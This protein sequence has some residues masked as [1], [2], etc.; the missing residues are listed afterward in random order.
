MKRSSHDRH[1]DREWLIPLALGLLALG[2]RLPGLDTGLWNDEIA[3]IIQ[4]FR[5]SFPANLSEFRGDNKHPL[6]ALLAHASL[7]MFGETAW[8]IRL[9]SLL[10]GVASVPMLYWLAR[11]LVGRREAISAALLLAV[12]YHHVWFSQSARGYSALLFFALLTTHQLLGMLRRS[13]RRAAIAFAICIALGTYAHL[14]FVFFVFTQFVVALVALAWP[15]RGTVRPDWRLVL[16]PFVVGGIISAALHYPMLQPMLDYFTQPSDQTEVSSPA[17]AVAEGI[18]VLRAGFGDAFGLAVVAL[19][20]AAPIGLA[21]V[22]TWF[23]RD[24]DVALIIVLAPLAIIAGAALGRGTMYPRFFFVLGGFF[25]LLVVRGAFATGAWLAQWPKGASD[26][27]RT[28]RGERLAMAAVGVLILASL[29]SLPREWSVPKQD[30]EGP[31]AMVQQQKA[32]GDQV[33]VA[34]VTAAVYLLYYRLP[35]TRVKTVADFDALR[36]QGKVW[37]IYTFPRYLDLYDPALA[38][39]VDADCKE[40]AVFPATLGGGEVIVCT[41]DAIA[42]A[43]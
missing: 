30:F 2:L 16:L 28:T 31:L 15:A 4:S 43:T 38:A 34:D 1:E 14:T 35:W 32:P 24:R 23:R 29:A 26:D 20:I 36:Q 39:H 10:F 9:P 6:Y 27:A 22:I 8:A 21:G 41:M 37:F 7:V 18:R 11:P 12:S 40:Q 19:A 42:P 25:V 5:T 3:A 17:W 33:A 13:D